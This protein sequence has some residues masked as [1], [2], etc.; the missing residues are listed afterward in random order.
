MLE[1]INTLPLLARPLASAIAHRARHLFMP[2]GPIFPRS[3]GA[4]SGNWRRFL[5][6][7]FIAICGVRI[8]LVERFASSIAYGDD[9]DG[10]ARRLLL[11]WSRGTLSW[12]VLFAAHNGDH[13]ILATRLWE[14]L[15]FT[16][17]G[18]WDPKLVM[19]AKVPVFA[20][21][22]TIFVHLFTGR[23]ERHRYATA[24]I[25]T[26]L[27]AFPFAF[28]NLLWAFQ[29][30][31]DFFLLAAALGWLAALSGRT[32]LALVLAALSILTLASGPIIAVSF[33][34][35]F[36][37]RWLQGRWRISRAFW[38]GVAA[39]GILAIGLMSP[40][41]VAKP[42]VGTPVDK[43]EML[44]RLYGWPYSNLMS[45]IE[46]LPETEKYVPARLLRLPSP[47]HSL[48]LAAA[49]VMHAHPIL[50][51][52]FDGVCGA[53]L[54]APTLL[55]LGAILRRRVPLRVGLG[56]LGLAGF[57]FLMLVA[58]AMARADEVTIA[59]RFLDHVSLAGFASL[60]AAVA[61]ASREPRWRRR[62]VAWSV[63]MGIGYA[64]TMV[65]TVAQMSRHA[66]AEAL[67]ILQ[68]YYA[69]TP[70]DH[71][72]MAENRAF[73]RFIVSDDP[74]QFM[75]EL[76]TPGLEKI[77][78]LEVTSP[79]APVGPAARLAFSFA[80]YGWLVALLGAGWACAMAWRAGREREPA[81]DPAL[82]ATAAA[83]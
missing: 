76:D 1:L 27:F 61:V 9:L 70:H 6:G 8:F 68:R 5:A 13:R 40:T 35:L 56:P 52:A 64:A 73:H 77:M 58:T 44:V 30:Q 4:G 11:P 26:A 10:I 51:V 19:I 49:R 39:L 60:A 7:C 46:R 36:A 18:S 79:G 45:I 16:I 28:A 15:W 31:F 69:T 57:A 23:L 32:V 54:L 12:S 22:A 29:S 24:G 3:G 74:T 47:D 63:V 33:I 48:L 82:E 50:P 2:N 67:S 72:V 71:A 37:V 62:L 78:P 83:S 21:A 75:S 42:H 43:A 66:P 25:L 65:I 20:A 17:N 38:H 41:A 14:I 81:G 80:R 34:P 55:L 53:I 59:P